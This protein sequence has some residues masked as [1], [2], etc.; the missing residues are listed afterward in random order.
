MI[1]NKWNKGEVLL[2]LPPLPPAYTKNTGIKPI[3]LVLDQDIGSEMILLVLE[4]EDDL[5][6][7]KNNFEKKLDIKVGALNTSFGPICFMLFIMPDPTHGGKVTY[8]N[9]INV[10]DQ[11]QLNIYKKLANQIYWH[12][13]IANMNGSVRGFIEFDNNYGLSN[14]L[15]SIENACNEKL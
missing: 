5:L 10:K 4:R 3:E 8:E 6:G 9:T 15:N 14:M 7:Y 2:K 1:N 12:V 13:V 11:G